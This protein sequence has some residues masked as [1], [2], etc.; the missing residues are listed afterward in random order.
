MCVSFIPKVRDAV[1]RTAALFAALEGG[2]KVDADHVRRAILLGEYWITQARN[3]IGTWSTAAG[4]YS[5]AEKI[6]RWLMKRPD[7]LA[8]FTVRDARYHGHIRGT[9]S[10][11]ALE[12]LE[13]HGWVRPVDPGTGYG[14]TGGPWPSSHRPSR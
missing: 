10:S 2:D 1:A 13:H 6:L 14:S 5:A 8:Q 4:A 9:E 12:V 11:A 3:L 7:P